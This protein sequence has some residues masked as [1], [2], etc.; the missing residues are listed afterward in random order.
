MSEFTAITTQEEFDKAIKGRLAQK[1]RE[2]E[3]KF[4]DYLSPDKVED[5]KRDYEKKIEE[6]NKLL[7]E[8]QA[9]LKENETAAAELKARAEKAEHSNLKSRIAYAHKLPMELADRLVGETE[10]ELNKDAESLSSIV[11]SGNVP[12]LYTRE[13]NHN[14]NGTGSSSAAMLNLLSQLTSTQN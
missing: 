11:G 2:I 10:E 13:S 8:A 9:K 7:K 4:K 3:E 5:L 1:D 6:S 12:P 14:N